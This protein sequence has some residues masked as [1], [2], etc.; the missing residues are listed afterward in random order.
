MN[1]VYLSPSPLLGKKEKKVR[2]LGTFGIR[3]FAD[4]IKKNI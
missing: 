4:I 1:G 2:S 3:V